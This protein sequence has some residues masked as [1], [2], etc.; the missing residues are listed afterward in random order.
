MPLLTELFSGKLKSTITRLS[1]LSLLNTEFIG[2]IT[3]GSI[4]GFDLK[5]PTIAL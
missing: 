3:I 2:D 4:K 5:G 1:K